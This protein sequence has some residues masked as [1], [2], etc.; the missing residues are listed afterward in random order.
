MEVSAILAVAHRDFIKLL[1]DPARIIATSLFPL[2]LIGVL[3]GGLD[4][5]VDTDYSFLTFTFTGVFA[6]SLF[7]SSAMGIISLI[8][9]RENDFSQEIFVSPISR[10]SIVFGK[11][12]GETL[13]AIPQGVA[14]VIFALLIGVPITLT[15]LAALVPITFVVCLFGGSFGILV[16]TNLSSQRTA[17]QVAPF[18]VFPQLFLAGVFFPVKSLPL[19]LDIASKVTPLRYAV[20]LTRGVFYAGQPDYAEVVV[21]TPPFNLLVMA[22]IFATFLVAGTWLFVR[23]ERNR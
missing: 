23:S 1:R 13:V 10:Y 2:L 21:Q 22:A 8:E 6:Q 18:L 14:I 7:T 19:Y 9:D 4:A 20:D 12:V 16:M 5:S 3:G 17:N 11:I 15:Q